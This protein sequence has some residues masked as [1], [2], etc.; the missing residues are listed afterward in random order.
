MDINRVFFEKYGG[1]GVFILTAI[2]IVPGVINYLKIRVT[3][4][5]V[6]FRNK[7][8]GGL[9][10]LLISDVHLGAVNSE[11]H[12]RR[13]IN[14]INAQNADVVLIAGDMFNNNFH[15]I[16]DPEKTAELLKTIKSKYGVFA[17]LGNHDAGKT[18][19][20]MADFLSKCNITLLNDEM[21]SVEDWNGDCLRTFFNVVCREVADKY[22]VDQWDVLAAFVHEIFGK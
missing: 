14:I 19:P 13:A 6:K 9:H 21:I 20:L 1:I 8:D 2:I 22:D 18:Y 7:I 5:N 17:C 16:I 3:K 10:V 4:Y 11:K 12:I 15:A